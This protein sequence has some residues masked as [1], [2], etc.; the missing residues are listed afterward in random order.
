MLR[1][2]IKVKNFKMK[3][4]DLEYVQINTKDDI[5]IKIY[6]DRLMVL[7]KEVKNRRLLRKS[8]EAITKCYEDKLSP[9]ISY[10]FSLGAPIPKELADIKSIY[11]YFIVLNNVERTYVD[12][13]LNN[14]GQ[15][16]Y[17]KPS[18]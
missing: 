13:L 8:I 14:F 18:D 4:A 9:T 3:M 5:M 12:E 17:Y 2:N 15:A 7:K 11:P 6:E 1:E 16:Q 10:I